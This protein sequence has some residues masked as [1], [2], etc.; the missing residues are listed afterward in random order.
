MDV[1]NRSR[2]RVGL[3]LLTAAAGPGQIGLVKLLLA[4]GADVNAKSAVDLF[5]KICT[6]LMA[7][8]EGG[9]TEIV[10]ILLEAG[11]D[12]NAS[13][14]GKTALDFAIENRHADVVDL[15]RA[16]GTYPCSSES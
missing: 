2:E 14:E 5:G 10:P 6:P 9:W 4:A 13:V 3:T 1:N 16:V 8:A 7:A 15:L 12:V 11:A